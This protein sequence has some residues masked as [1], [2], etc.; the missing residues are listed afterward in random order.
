MSQSKHAKHLNHLTA[1]AA[2]SSKFPGLTPAELKEANRQLDL[3]GTPDE[4]RPAALSA[5]ASISPDD[6]ASALAETAAILDGKESDSEA[7]A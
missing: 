4:L 2:A 7:A 3:N 6:R 5:L 1:K